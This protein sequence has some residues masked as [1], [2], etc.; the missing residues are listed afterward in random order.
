MIDPA[1]FLWAILLLPI[2]GALICL[3]LPAAAAVLALLPWVV[4]ALALLALYPA[5]FV[6]G[7]GP[8]YSQ[9]GWFFLDALSAYHL[10][11]MSLVFVLASTYARG[12]FS[13]DAADP[14]HSG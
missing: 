4:V 1:D 14:T 12:Y 13:P 9:G 8:I 7:N 3:V 2:A 11:I 10:L 5:A 6:F